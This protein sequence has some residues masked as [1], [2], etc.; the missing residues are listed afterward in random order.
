MGGVKVMMMR[1]AVWC[2]CDSVCVC[3]AARVLQPGSDTAVWEED[4]RE[5]CEEAEGVRLRS[6][7]SS[8]SFRP[9]VFS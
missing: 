3:D 1:R 6:K 4:L 2:E 9:H 5:L 8:A 7:R